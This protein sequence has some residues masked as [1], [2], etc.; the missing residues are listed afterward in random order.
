[1]KLPLKLTFILLALSLLAGCAITP[2][3][4][5]LTYE[6]QTRVDPLTGAGNVSVQVVIMDQ[7]LVNDSVGRKMNGYGMEMAPI[8]ATNNVPEFIKH[9]I[10]TELVNRGFK[11]GSGNTVTV[12]GELAKFYNEFKEGFWAG[13]AVA[14]LNLNVMIKNGNGT[15]VYSRLIGGRGIVP[16]IQMASGENARIALNCALKDGMATLFGDPSF[17]DTLLKVGAQQQIS[18]REN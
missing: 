15:I 9:A 1:M 10:E 4:I 7:R 6:P 11:I 16:N 17:T 12:V 14:E 3:K 8:T 13:S 18:K 5:Q 2:S